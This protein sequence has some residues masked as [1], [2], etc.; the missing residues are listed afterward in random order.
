M[1]LQEGEQRRETAEA[2]QAYV[3]AQKQN[4]LSTAAIPPGSNDAPNCPEPETAN[5]RGWTVADAF[6]KNSEHFCENYFDVAQVFFL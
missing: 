5:S 1:L 3:A 2:E 6:D 4:I